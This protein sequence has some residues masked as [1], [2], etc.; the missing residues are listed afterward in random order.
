MKKLFSLCLLSIGL[1]LSAQFSC[2]AFKSQA[3]VTPSINNN[4]KS[5]SIDILHYDLFL[6]L[7][8]I[9]QG[10]FK[11]IA[12]ID[13]RLLHSGVSSLPLDLHKLRV[14]SVRWRNS[15]GQPFQ[16]SGL[17]YQYVDSLLSIRSSTA[18]QAGDSLQVQIFY[19]GQPKK[20]ASGWGG[21]IA[22][23]GYFY[24]LGVGFAANPHVFG[25]A[26]FPCFDNFVERSTYRIEVLSKAPL[27]PLLVGDAINLESQQGDS[28]RYSSRL[29]QAIPTYLAS[30]ALAN[31]EI[32]RDTV[33]GIQDTLEILLAAKAADTAA[34]RSSFRNLKAILRGFETDFGPYQWPRIGYALTTLG[35]MEHATSIHFPL[36]LVDGSLRGEDIIAHEL[37]HH[38]FGNLITCETAEDMWFNEGLAEY[39]SH[40]YQER[41]YGTSRYLNTVRANAWDV[42]NQAHRRDQGYKALYGQENEF[43]YGF[44]VYQKGAMVGHNLRH[45]LGDSLFF[46]SLQQL[47]ADLAYQNI[48]TAQFRDSLIAYTGHNAL[49]DF[50]QNWV[51]SAGFPQFSVHH[52]QYDSAQGLT[53]ELKQRIRQ[54]PALY[55]QVPVD[56]T[57]IA[58]N[59]NEKHWRLS[60]SGA[61][62][63]HSNLSLPFKPAV[64]LCSYS[65]SLLTATGQDILH[66]DQAG[67]QAAAYGELTVEALQIQDS[68]EIIVQHHLTGAEKLSSNPFDFRLHPGRFW[69]I[70]Q[71]YQETGDSI[72]V[73]FRFDGSRGR[74][75]ALLR[76]GNDSLVLLY[77]PDGRSQ[78]R[79][80]PY[81]SKQAG[82]PNSKVGSISVDRLL[83]GD[84]TLANSKES[85]GLLEGLEHQ[86][87]QLYPN[88]AQDRIEI[89]G[90]QRAS[91]LVRLLASNGQLLWQKGLSLKSG[92][93]SLPLPDLAPGHYQVQIDRQES[94]PLLLKP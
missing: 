27:R 48:N 13:L 78:W 76:A 92:H 56:V 41:L 17:S 1:T 28:L 64:V 84:Y 12:T 15:P 61:S 43:T 2:Q 37:A 39:C 66:F 85:I 42:L 8:G 77:R 86:P 36:S 7:Y 94:I 16:S 87:F 29:N 57:A 83:N 74:D 10:Q 73:D 59:G 22:S 51:Y 30:F 82:S 91:I 21:F 65:G 50:F 25:R 52:W 69:T 19:G 49:A 72:Q 75:E 55:Q 44:H 62:S 90:P 14:D 40:L 63:L 58:P 18:W 5:D 4:A 20:D 35:A 38:W 54:A 53:V 88:P 47:F 26:W 80:Y 45:Y 9:A 46:S 67:S 3:G 11:A 70:H 93:G 81:Q 68:L 33:V 79:L 6:D 60:H 32:M 71:L 34:M 23:N 31:Y 89:S 24:N